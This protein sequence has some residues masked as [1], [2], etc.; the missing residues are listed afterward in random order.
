MLGDNAVSTQ[1]FSSIFFVF[2]VFCFLFSLWM[3]QE[4]K[5]LLLCLKRTIQ[6]CKPG[7]ALSSENALF[8]Y[9]FNMKFIVKLVS[10]VLIPTGAL[11]NTHYLPS[12][13]LKMLQGTS[14]GV[15]V[16]QGKRLYILGNSLQYDSLCGDPT[17]ISLLSASPSFIS[18]QWPYTFWNMS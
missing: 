17:W 5:G 11:F 14:G 7:I 4:S 2:F 18:L 13:P 1:D 10:T 6:A 12:P 16:H 8:I 3:K 9:F 15:H